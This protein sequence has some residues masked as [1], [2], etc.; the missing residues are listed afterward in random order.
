MKNLLTDNL[1][2]FR[3]GAAAAL[4]LAVGAFSAV[5]QDE[6][7]AENAAETPS[8]VVDE[9]A[10]NARGGVN[11]A[12]IPEMP[13]HREL[14]K[15]RVAL[16]EY[17]SRYTVSVEV[18]Y[19][20]RVQQRP[21]G[22]RIPGMGGLGGPDMSDPFYRY[23]L[24]P[25]SGLV[26]GPN[27]ILISDR[28]LG[29]FN[30]HGAGS[31]VQAITVTLPNGERWPANV[32]GRHQQIDLALLELDC[33]I[34]ETCPVLEVIEFPQEPIAVTRG[35]SILVVGRGQNPLGTLVNPGIVS[36]VTRESARAFQLDARVSNSTLGAPVVNRSGQLVG[37]ITLHTHTRLGQASGVSNAAYIAEVRDA[38]ALLREGAFIP[39]PP[40][41]FMG[42][43]AEK[44]WPDRPGLVVGRVV[45]GTGAAE[46]GLQENDIIL[47]VNGEDMNEVEDLIN[48]IAR[49]N[50][51]DTLDVLIIRGE[52]ELT[53]KITL[54]ARE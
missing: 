14:E 49:Q 16:G 54:G 32:V 15:H 47:Q 39:T 26:V 6:G 20:R 17:V 35:E 3:L 38:Y 37:M 34:Y 9:P 30:E 52:E 10:R 8:E 18:D 4:L 28:C 24:G 22:L 11:Y 31:E 44:R 33:I 27:H 53:L 1:L 7:A 21:G 46:A 12:E 36:A 51:G 42:V 43:Q 2:P 25:F 19:N 13:L 50:V 41:P 45:P 23:D 40:Q 29:E 5:A 48:I